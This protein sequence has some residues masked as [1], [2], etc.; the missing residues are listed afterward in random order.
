MQGWWAIGKV[1]PE[2]GRFD[3][4]DELLAVLRQGPERTSPA[5]TGPSGVPASCW[6]LATIG[7]ALPWLRKYTVSGVWRL[8]RRCGLKLRSAQVQQY[9]PDP[10][11]A[12]KEAHLFACLQQSAAQ[13]DT[14]VFLFLDEMGYSRWPAATP[15]WWEGTGGGAPVADR[16]QS[17]QQQWRIIG[18]LNALSG[19]VDYLDGYIVGRAKVIAMYQAIAQRYP[20]AKRI[21]VAQ[22]NWS[23]H[24]HPDVLTA[25]QALPAIEPVWLP[26]YAPWLNPIEKL[27]RWL[28]QHVLKMHHLADDW[29]HLQQRVCAF[30][31]QFADGSTPLLRYVGLLGNGK[32]A[33]A[34][35][36]H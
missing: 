14:R 19:A 24:T 36:G 25:L 30:L 13:P 21:Y 1:E 3:R 33:S 28:R 35:H 17:K 11:Y 10:D 18:V 8:L 23:I 9:S 16:Q 31:H 22:D 32:L 2:G 34:I 15:V 20:G 27:W 26:T 6:Q 7:P 4:R 29:P 12:V 5:A